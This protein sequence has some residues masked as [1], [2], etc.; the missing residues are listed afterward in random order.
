MF[1]DNAAPDYFVSWI[2]VGSRPGESTFYR[3]EHDGMVMR[4]GHR[5]KTQARHRLTF[6][7][8]DPRF[9]EPPNLQVAPFWEDAPGGVGHA[10]TIVQLSSSEATIASD[11]GAPNYSASFLA[12]GTNAGLVARNEFAVGET[13]IRTG[14]GR[15]VLQ[16]TPVKEIILG[17]WLPPERTLGDGSE[18]AE[19]PVV[20]VTPFW[21]GQTGVGHAETITDIS[22]DYV[23]TA[24][25][26]SGFN[27]S[28]SWIAIGPR[29]LP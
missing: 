1:S 17:G 16:G 5:N 19:P 10:E 28:V 20:V 18:F 27:Y 7:G 11:N 4:W 29:R 22:T 26:N 15:D 9:A 23:R 14:I 2:A 8:G 12:T 3:L 21:E 24:S 25:G 13:L 6:S